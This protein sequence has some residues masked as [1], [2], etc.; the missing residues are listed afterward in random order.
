[1]T[2]LS[3]DLPAVIIKVILFGHCKEFVL[4][5]HFHTRYMCSFGLMGFRTV[6]ITSTSEAPTHAIPILLLLHDRRRLNF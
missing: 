1:M 3:P 5:C 2:S 4:F 6:R